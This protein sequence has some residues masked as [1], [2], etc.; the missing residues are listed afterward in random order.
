MTLPGSAA[1]A[2]EETAFHQILAHQ[3]TRYPRLEIQD[4]YK[5]TYQA[6]MG[7]EH[8]VQDIVAA[9]DWL[10]RELS[11]LGD[12]PEEP[13]VDTISA[14]GRIARLHLR[15]YVAAG[16]DPSALLTAFVRTANEHRGIWE[17]LR[18]YWS[19]AVRLA[20]MGGLPFNQTDLLSFW[21]DVE[22]KGFPV[23]HHSA[24]YRAAYKPAYRV[25]RREFLLW[26]SGS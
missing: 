4:L 23:V 22:A 18:R 11:Q 5:L 14:D 25:I 10:E 19:Y 9:R 7:A 1:S 24:E 17:Q 20:A 26:P 21:A 8:A 16:G 15:P 6:A 3:V 13:V 12:G 2:A